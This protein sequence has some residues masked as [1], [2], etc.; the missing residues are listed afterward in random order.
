MAE[1][2]IPT[3]HTFAMNNIFTGCYTT[4]S[5]VKRGNRRAETALIAA[6]GLSAL[7]SREFSVPYAD[8]Q[9]E[10]AWQNVLLTHHLVQRSGTDAIG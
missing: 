3:L 9:F 2:F 1:I 5:R 6:E 8:R 10:S 4:Q 7:A